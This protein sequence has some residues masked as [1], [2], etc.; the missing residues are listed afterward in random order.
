MLRKAFSLVE[1]LVV[2]SII[3]ILI[4]LLLPAIQS[5]REAGRRLQCMNNMKQLATACLAYHDSLGTFPPAMT[6]PTKGSDQDRDPGD[7]YQWGPNWAI[8]ILPFC[9]YN[10]LYREFDLNKPISDPANAAARATPVPTM[11][12]PTDS[13][14]NSRPYNPFRLKREGMNWARG[15]YGAN[16]AINFLSDYY[17]NGHM[18][19][20]G[21]PYFFLGP[22]SPGWLA[23][24]G[25]A[26][27][28]APISRGVMGCNEACSL[29]QITD[30][31]SHTI[32]LGELRAGTT[33]V[34]R[35]GIWAMGAAGASSLWGHGVWDDHGPNADA[36]GADDLKF[37][38]EITSAAGG[39]RILQLQDMGC[40]P[41]R[42]KSTQATA[43][44]QHPGGVNVAMC[45]GSVHFISDS[46][47]HGSNSDPVDHVVPSDPS[48]LHVWERLNV[49][50]D[51]QPIDDN[52]W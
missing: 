27:K 14:Y 45:D 26:N 20:P 51:G 13:A 9:E 42:I 43:R 5:S 19:N 49:S 41:Q 7:T 23:T 52:A 21:G 35:R 31:A 39:T 10:G 4:T 48:K 2:M 8:R 25:T 18:G 36:S 15:N 33:P 17:D 30:G 37:G 22:N 40:H 38:P 6:I 24:G 12:C 44:S 47:D 46:I 16:G 50:C 1:V 11:L 3:G 28:A 29:T 34:D 32:M